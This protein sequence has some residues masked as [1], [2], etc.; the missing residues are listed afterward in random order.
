MVFL[1]E[2][3]SA[4]SCEDVFMNV[5]YSRAVVQHPI[6]G[7]AVQTGFKAALTSGTWCQQGLMMLQRCC[8][9]FLRQ[10]VAAAQHEWFV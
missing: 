2:L 10:Q 7:E 5:P 3:P 6:D 9:D 8:S 4:D 1:K